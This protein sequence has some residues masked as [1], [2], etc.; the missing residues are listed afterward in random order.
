M[1]LKSFNNW[2]I[3]SKIVSISLVSIIL[4]FAVGVG[5]FL[6]FI[7]KQLM[8]DKQKEL[9]NVTEVFQLVPASTLMKSGGK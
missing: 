5:I 3:F 6:P 4:P 2:K 1:K 9:S 8:L 7:E